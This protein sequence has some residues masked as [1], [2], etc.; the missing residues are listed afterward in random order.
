M[1]ACCPLECTPAVRTHA[2]AGLCHRGGGHGQCATS[3]EPKDCVRHHRTPRR[4]LL[5]ER[6]QV[7]RHLSWIKL[8]PGM[9]AGGSWNV[10]VRRPSP[11]YTIRTNGTVFNDESG[12]GRGRFDGT[13]F[14]E[15][16]DN[17]RPNAYWR[18]YWAFMNVQNA[19][20]AAIISSRVRTP[21]RHIVGQRAA[22][23]PAQWYKVRVAPS[24]CLLPAQ[25]YMVRVAPSS[26][27]LPAQWYMV[28][29][30]PSCCLA[31]TVA[32]D[33]SPDDHC[34]L[35]EDDA[36]A[37]VR[38]QHR[39]PHCSQLPAAHLH[40]RL[41]KHHGAVLPRT[42][43]ERKRERERELQRTRARAR[44]RERERKKRCEKKQSVKEGP[45]LLA[46]WP[47]STLVK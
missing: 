32:T 8:L 22:M 17:V 12:R 26:C 18:N 7:S 35:C 10:C 5:L 4:S 34:Q 46:T 36:V 31:P 19:F 40:L 30:A 42:E 3:G 20:D 47:S 28:R 41:S 11:R 9:H 13:K 44:Q 23:L 37:R 1:H 29:V 14:T 27:L 24:S 38:T 45:R 15:R 6:Y 43:R 2:A 39:W 16:W 33:G 21:L 25:W